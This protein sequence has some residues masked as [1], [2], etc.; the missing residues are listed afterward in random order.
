MNRVYN[1]SLGRY[2]ES[3]RIGI[4]GGKNHLYVYV[5]NRPVNFIDPEGM[6]GCPGTWQAGG[7]IFDETGS[8]VKVD[9]KGN[10]YT[11]YGEKERTYTYSNPK[12][13]G[14]CNC[15][16][17]AIRCTYDIEESSQMRYGRQYP[18]QNIKWGQWA[19]SPS[20]LIGKFEV[21]WDCEKEAFM[22]PGIFTRTTW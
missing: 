2:N 1:A 17:K 4:Q 20:H 11:L 12:Q 14:E 22:S 21:G 7:P 6:S 10:T 16:T 9:N 5:G 19:I 18:G 13:S 15:N 8:E 3:D